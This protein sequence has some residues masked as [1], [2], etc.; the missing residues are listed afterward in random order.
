MTMGSTQAKRIRSS[1]DP[2]RSIP[3][4]GEKVKR[5]YHIARIYFCLV[6]A[7]DTCGKM[8]TY[9]YKKIIVFIFLDGRRALA[10]SLF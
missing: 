8:I 2:L 9:V 7:S 4:V 6:L 10:H 5:A 1:P 3:I